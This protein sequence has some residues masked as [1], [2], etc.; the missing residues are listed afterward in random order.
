MVTTLVSLVALIIAIF[1]SS[2]TVVRYIFPTLTFLESTDG[3]VNILLLGN[4]GG[5]HAGPYLTDTVMVASINIKTNKVYLISLPRDFWVDKLKV[6][7]NAVYEVGQSK[8]AGLN[9]DKEIVGDILGLPLHYGLRVDFSGFEKAIDQLEGIDIDVERSFDDY[10]YPIAGKEEDLCD[11]REEEKE[12]SEEEAK[13]LN[14]SS[15][16]QKVLIAPD[17]KIA[18]DSAEP[19]KGF[20]YFKCRYEH[21]HFDKGLQ[22]INGEVALK[23]VRSRMGTAGEGSDFARSK[24]QQKVIEATRKKVLSLETVVNPRRITD[25]L[26][27]FGKSVEVDIPIDDIIEI[28]SISKKLQVGANFVLDDS[29]LL[30]RPKAQDFGGAYVLVP[31]TSDYNLIHEYVKKVLSGEINTNEATASARSGN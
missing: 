9:L 26:S 4:A 13:R 21:I 5:A 18:T 14:I 3:R 20:E 17:G 23:F 25:L 31:K 7:L 28:Y 12:F 30:V 19:E 15:G 29:N 2:S 24:R 11:F 16:K 22:H 6:K 1:S 10:N 27:T 8:Y